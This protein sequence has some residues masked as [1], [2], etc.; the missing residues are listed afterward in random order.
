[1]NDLHAELE[2]KNQSQKSSFYTRF[3]GLQRKS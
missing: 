2:K 3:G 1:M